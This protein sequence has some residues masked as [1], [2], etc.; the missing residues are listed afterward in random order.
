MPEFLLNT[1]HFFYISF[2]IICCIIQL[3]RLSLRQNETGIIHI[4]TF[5]NYILYVAG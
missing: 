1:G 4:I 3:F 5:D 2:T